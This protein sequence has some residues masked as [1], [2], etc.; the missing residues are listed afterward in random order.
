MAHG[1]TWRHG[2][3]LQG[4]REFHQR[5]AAVRRWQQRQR[6]DVLPAVEQFPHVAGPDRHARLAARPR[7]TFQRSSMGSTCRT[8]GG[9]ASRLTVNAGVRYDLVTGLNFDQSKNPNFVKVQT[10]ARAGKLNGDRRSRELRPRSAV[11]PEQHSAPHRRRLRR[12]RHRQGH[13]PRAD[14]AS[15]MTSDI[16][17]RTCCRP[18]LDASGNG[19]GLVFSATRSRQA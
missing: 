8:I 14:G 6:R 4:R 12:H 13:H 19:Y 5:A 17:T 11:G 1:G 10:A 2:S 18:A 16:P 15:T 9:S 7:P 3:H